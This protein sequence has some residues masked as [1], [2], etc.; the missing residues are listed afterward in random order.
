MVIP[1]YAQF[2]DKNYFALKDIDKRLTEYIH[3][4]GINV[5]YLVSRAKRKRGKKY[6]P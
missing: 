3:R 2:L 5:R 6:F 4:E 1:A